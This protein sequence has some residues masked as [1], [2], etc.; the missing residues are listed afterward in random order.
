MPSVLW[1]LDACALW[2]EIKLPPRLLLILTLFG[3]AAAAEATPVA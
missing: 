2:R 3:T 1:K